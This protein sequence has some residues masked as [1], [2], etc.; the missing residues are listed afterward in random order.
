MSYQGT[1]AGAVVLQVWTFTTR[2]VAGALDPSASRLGGSYKGGTVGKTIVFDI[3]M[4]DG[5]GNVVVPSQNPVFDI[6]FSGQ[7]PQ[8]PRWS[9]VACG[10]CNGVYPFHMSCSS[11]DTYN[12][13]VYVNGAIVIGSPFNVTLPKK[14]KTKKKFVLRL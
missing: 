6:K 7:V 2:C 4:T 5:F 13:T 11:Q 3:T 8:L 14:K 9:Q 1:T 10:A 12:M